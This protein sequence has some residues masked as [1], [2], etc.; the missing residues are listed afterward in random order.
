MSIMFCRNN[1]SYV[2]GAIHDTGS[3]IIFNRENI[4]VFF[5][6]TANNNGGAIYL[7]YTNVQINGN[8]FMKFSAGN[9]GGGI[10]Q[11]TS[12]VKIGGNLSLIFDGNSTINDGGTI[13]VSYGAIYMK[14]N[15]FEMILKEKD[16][17]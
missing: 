8:T 11:L 9:S 17:L 6:N 13:C 10:Y 2:G 14:T 4:T 12:D 16:C 7:F 5:S 1:A 15:M 3:N